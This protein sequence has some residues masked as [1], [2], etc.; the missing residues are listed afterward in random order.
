MVKQGG[1]WREVE[2]NVALDYVAHGLKDITRDHGGDAVAA[3]SAPNATLEEMYLLGKVMKGLGSGNVDFRPRQSDFGSDF[4]RAGTPWLG[5]R[6]AD[7]K[8]LD[9]ALVV[10]SFLRKDH[11]LIAQRLRQAAKKWTKVSLI[12]VTGDDPLINLHASLTV[13]P[14]QLALSLAAVVKATAEAKG[15]AAPAGL[16]NVAVSEVDRRISQSLLEGE[17]RAIFLGNVATQCDDATQ[18]HALAL[19]LG[20]LTGATVGFLGEAA[21]VVGGHVG[22]ALPKGANARQMFEQPRKG[23]VL[24]GIEPEFDCANPQVTLAALKQAE[25]VVVMSAFQQESALE[26]ADVML[27]IAP[28]TE[29]SGTFVNIEG[30]VQSFNG[31][32]KALGETR[33]AWKVL[34][35]LGNVLNLDGFDYQ[36]SECVRD[37]VLGKGGEFVSG[38]DNGLNGVAIN[39]SQPVAGL[40]RIA[41]VP[42]HFADALARRSPVLRQTADGVAPQARINEKTLADLG[43]A[44]GATVRVKQGQ[45]EATLVAKVDKVPA[46]CVRVAAAH[47]ST[48]ALG[49]MFGQISVERA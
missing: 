14:A 42:I 17:K 22:W 13:A 46:G 24:L 47:A 29:T 21:N 41:D 43:I 49:A 26:Y 3:L 6:L 35:V 16:E 18:L 34:R 40:Q 38:L 23:Y 12:S 5:M 9:A 45:G 28:F 19:E 27:P 44:D 10:G 25:M 36:T 31:V 30:R 7:I 48:A 15:V 4:K 37:E 11:P 33:P 8:D 2:W 1:E 39:L 32:V 20:K